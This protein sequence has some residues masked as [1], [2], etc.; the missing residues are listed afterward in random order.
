MLT[1]KRH[2][3]EQVGMGLT[4]FDIDD[5]LFN[6]KAKVQVKK[7]GKVLKQLSASDYNSYRL[8]DGESYDY[9]EFKNAS[10]FA[11]TSTPIARMIAKAKAIIKNSVAQGSKVI[12]STARSDMDNKEIF[13]RALDAHGIST[14]NIHVER[15]GNLNLGSSAKNKKVIFRKYL[16][17]GRYSRVRFFDDDMNNLRSF[18]S[19]SKE[20]PNIEF[21][22]YHVGKDG[23]TKTIR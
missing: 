13:L 11:K 14:D 16:R 19:L 23:R 10:L 12:I 18:L 4:V 2:L 20:Y 3:L 6:T 15:A 17:S 21:S 9:G 5:T 22:A 1:F 8:Q 7:D